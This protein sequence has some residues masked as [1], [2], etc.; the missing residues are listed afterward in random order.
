V[1]VWVYLAVLHFIPLINKSVSVPISCGF[2]YYC[3]I[4]QLETR[5]GDTSRSSFIV[6]NCLPSLVFLFSI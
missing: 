2:Y 4:I 3:F 1:G 5:D 6:Q